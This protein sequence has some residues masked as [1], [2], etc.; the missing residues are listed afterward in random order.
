MT[1]IRTTITDPIGLTLPAIAFQ[2]G[3][4]YAPH[5]QIIAATKLD[6][7]RVLFIDVTRGLDYCT[8]APCDLTVSAVM[9]AYDHNRTVRADMISGEYLYYGEM[10]NQLIALTEEVPSLAV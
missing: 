2:S 6:D 4:V 3:R 8:T 5:G 9:E 1:I 7:G 10:L